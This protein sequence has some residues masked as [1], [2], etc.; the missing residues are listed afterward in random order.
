MQIILKVDRYIYNITQLVL[1]TYHIVRMSASVLC[2][3][4]NCEIPRVFLYVRCFSQLTSGVVNS[5]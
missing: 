5:L 4:K 3:L 2:G 1:L